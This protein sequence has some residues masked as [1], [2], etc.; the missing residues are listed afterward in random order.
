MF[1][2]KV[3]VALRSLKS[4]LNDAEA[5]LVHVDI[6]NPLLD[7]IQNHEKHGFAVA[8]KGCCGT[9]NIEVSILCNKFSKTCPNR[10]VYLFWDNYHLTERGYNIITDRVLTK[11]LKHLV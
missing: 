4:S 2:A 10:S 11:Y 1:N 8:N 7:L 6:Y 5:R 3:P 9:G